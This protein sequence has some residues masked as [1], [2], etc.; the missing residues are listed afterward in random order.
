M[1]EDIEMIKTILLLYLVV[2][3]LLTLIG[4]G[5]KSLSKAVDSLKPTPTQ[6]MRPDYREPTKTQAYLFRLILSLGIIAF[7]PALLPGILKEN[8]PRKAELED[9]IIYESDDDEIGFLL[10]G[11]HGLIT[12]KNCNYKKELTSFTHGGNHSTSGYQCEACAKLTTRS[13]TEPFKNINIDDNQ[14]LLDYSPSERARKVEYLLGMAEMC[15][16]YMKETPKKEWLQT[17]EP[18]ATEYRKKLSQITAKEIEAI[19]KKRKAFEAKYKASLLCNCGGKLC[20]D[21]S[22]ICPKCKSKRLKY[23]MEY[24]T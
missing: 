19:K 14:N 11:G 6:K 13:R 2:G 16:R 1:A 24:I 10:M 23:E 4:P 17:W 15:E 21:K 9:E 3:F 20:R 8:A 18:T 22:I 7:W 5:K 12:C